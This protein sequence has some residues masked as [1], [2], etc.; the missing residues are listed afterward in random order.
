MRPVVK[1]NIHLLGLLIILF[2]AEYYIDIRDYFGNEK[3]TQINE[4]I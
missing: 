3:K 1:S 4:V 2:F